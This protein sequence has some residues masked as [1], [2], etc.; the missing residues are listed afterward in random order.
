MKY[1][2]IYAAAIATW[3]AVRTVVGWIRYR[4]ML[5]RMSEEAK[6]SIGRAMSEAMNELLLG[7]ASERPYKAT[8]TSDTLVTGPTPPRATFT[9]TPDKES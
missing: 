9:F 4:L 3:L 8:L 6:T 7:T 5:R 2:T 1:L